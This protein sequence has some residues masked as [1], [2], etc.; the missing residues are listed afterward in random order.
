[1]S[2]IR[3]YF[4]FAKIVDLFFVLNIFMIFAEMVLHTDFIAPYV[5]GVIRTPEEMAVLGGQMESGFYG[6]LA[7]LFGHPL[8]AA[9][10]L[11][12][13]LSPTR[14]DADAA[15]DR[16]TRPVGLVDSSYLAIF[17]TESR[18]SMVATT[19]IL[20]LYLAFLELER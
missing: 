16:R 13:I 2:R 18:A 7:A 12:F 4:F 10:C 3:L 15:F 1:M 20:A 5:A 14:L 8:N 17:P 11:A 19:I 6:R 9:M